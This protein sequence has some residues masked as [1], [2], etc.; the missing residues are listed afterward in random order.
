MSYT[1]KKR[2]SKKTGR[3]EFTDISNIVHNRGR[4]SFFFRLFCWSS[5]KRLLLPA[6]LVAFLLLHNGAKAFQKIQFEFAYS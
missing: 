6:Y 5:A 1:R 2:V 3:V 4:L